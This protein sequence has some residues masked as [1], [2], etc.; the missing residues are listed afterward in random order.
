V[1]GELLQEPLG[2]EL[3]LQGTPDRSQGAEQA[4]KAPLGSVLRG[5]RFVRAFRVNL[6]RVRHTGE[7][8][9]HEG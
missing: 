5:G 2:I 9:G 8:M 1:R 7:P 3:F 6:L 4:R